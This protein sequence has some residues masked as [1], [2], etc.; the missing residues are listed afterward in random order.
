M[1]MLTSGPL[2]PSLRV[3]TGLA[4]AGE[5]FAGAVL[6]SSAFADKVGAKAT[7]TGA[8]MALRRKLRRDKFE[9]LALMVLTS[10]F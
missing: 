8:I 3:G 5:L 2:R 9:F 1:I 7:P 4:A 10:Q 6:A